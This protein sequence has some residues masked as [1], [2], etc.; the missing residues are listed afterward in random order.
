MRRSSRSWHTSLTARKLIRGCCTEF[1]CGSAVRG[2]ALKRATYAHAR[3]PAMLAAC[4]AGFIL[5][6]SRG[7]RII[8]CARV[9]NCV[10]GLLAPILC[11]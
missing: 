9:H 7:G 8:E 11:E 3:V 6:L 5:A 10:A 2:D 1:V 4:R